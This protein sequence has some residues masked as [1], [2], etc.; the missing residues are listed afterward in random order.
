M[1]RHIAQVCAVGV[2][3]LQDADAVK[4]DFSSGR[5]KRAHEHADQRGLA[6]AVGAQQRMHACAQREADV[7]DRGMIAEIAGEMF[8]LQFHENVPFCV[9]R[10]CSS[11]ST[12]S[13]MPRPRQI[14]ISVCKVSMA[15]II[16][17]LYRRNKMPA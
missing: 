17:M 2:I 3:L 14:T 13:M 9:L 1:L 10:L 12:I 15:L 16:G 6:A 7:I 11:V 8:A 4:G 5:R